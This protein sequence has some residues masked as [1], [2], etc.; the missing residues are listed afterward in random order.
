MASVAS[1]YMSY[2]IYH[3]V[4]KNSLQVKIRRFSRR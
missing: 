2:E 4:I 1:F 3:G